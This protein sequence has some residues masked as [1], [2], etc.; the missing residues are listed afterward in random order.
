[1][2]QEKT[3]R[4]LQQKQEGGGT[5]QFV[6]NRQNRQC[7]QLFTMDSNGLVGTVSIDNE[8]NG[9]HNGHT[10]SRHVISEQ[11][12]RAR[13]IN[14]PRLNAVSFWRTHDFAHEAFKKVF[15][16][17]QNRGLK[18]WAGESN[19]NPSQTR[20]KVTGVR[21]GYIIYR[22]DINRTQYAQNAEGFVYKPN[23]KPFTSNNAF[24]QLGLVTLYPV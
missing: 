22:R 18:Y 14:N 12:A 21:G 11:A 3:A 24:K 10:I 19:Y 16:G 1:M 2:Y 15:T 20:V 6:N 17:R 23:N 4:T 7:I 13:L 8:E 5:L 9:P